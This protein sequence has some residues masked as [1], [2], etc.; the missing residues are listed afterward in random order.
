M[1]P[2][3][4]FVVIES[5]TSGESLGGILSTFIK[6]LNKADNIGNEY[7]AFG[8]Y[9]RGAGRLIFAFAEAGDVVRELFSWKV[10]G[11]SLISHYSLSISIAD[12]WREC[13]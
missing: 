2:K 12:G 1:K 6:H 5:L 10:V 11:W 8:P 3:F 13:S 9:G 7:G 4:I